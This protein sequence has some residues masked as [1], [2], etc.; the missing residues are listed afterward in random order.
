[1]KTVV[2][3]LV[4][5]TLATT[6]VMAIVDKPHATYHVTITF[7]NLT[8][9]NVANLPSNAQLEQDLLNGWASDPDSANEPVPT[10]SVW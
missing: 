7:S 8:L 5:A 9:Q 2:I 1:M 4:L 10:V 6:G 3:T